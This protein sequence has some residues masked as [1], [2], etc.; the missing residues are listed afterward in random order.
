MG[1]ASHD[2]IMDLLLVF[3]LMVEGILVQIACCVDGTHSEPDFGGTSESN[4][5]GIHPE[6]SGDP[7]KA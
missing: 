4:G 2:D 5:G 1:L 7:G 3:L 6:L